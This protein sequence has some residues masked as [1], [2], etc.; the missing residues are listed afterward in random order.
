[1]PGAGSDGY[2][3]QV[4]DWFTDPEAVAR[5]YASEEALRERW[6]AY[7][8]L[9]EGP[10]EDEVLKSRI[11]AARPRRLLEVGSGFGEGWRDRA[12]GRHACVAVPG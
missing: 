7:D 5:E 2:S 12:S 11:L 10:N 9:V 3:E 6:A 1:M 8:E 4:G